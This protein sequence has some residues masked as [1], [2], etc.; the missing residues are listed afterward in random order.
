MVSNL[1]TMGGTER[2]TAN[3]SRNLAQRY[4]CHII[5]QWDTGNH[6]YDIAEGVKVFNLYPEKRRL[7]HMAWDATKRRA[8]RSLSRWGEIMGFFRF[9]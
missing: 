9:W 4:D 3:L 5:T 7:R 6:A 2:V 1:C 8:S